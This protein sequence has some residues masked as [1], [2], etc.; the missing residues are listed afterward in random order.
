MI[1]RWGSK[2]QEAGSRKQGGNDGSPE[3]APEN[4][5]RIEVVASDVAEARQQHRKRRPHVRDGNGRAF[6]EPP[7]VPYPQYPLRD[8][9]VTEV[10]ADADRIFLVVS[11][12]R[13]RDEHPWT[14]VLERHDDYWISRRDLQTLCDSSAAASGYLFNREGYQDP[15]E[16]LRR[17][18]ELLRGEYYRVMKA[19]VQS[20]RSRAELIE[21]VA[22]LK[23][24]GEEL[25]AQ[26]RRK[27]GRGET[28]GRRSPAAP[29]KK[30]S[31]R[32]SR[33]RR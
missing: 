11:G 14:L 26:L 17:M 13:A 5:A 15:L 30:L 16:M 1:D 19:K 32:R 10:L 3:K 6:V 29:R 27:I 28:T 20:D 24:E 22:R 12:T 21:E 33:R 18:N 7:P 4:R 25:K 9:V 2:K 23:S 8:A 31:P